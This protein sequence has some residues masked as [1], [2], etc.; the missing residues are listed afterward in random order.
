MDWK[1]LLLLL[2][3]MVR[4]VVH[5]GRLMMT[6][7]YLL[8]IM[9]RVV[10]RVEGRLL[11]LDVVSILLHLLRHLVVIDGRLLLLLRRHRLLLRL[12]QPRK[13][14]HRPMRFIVHWMGHAIHAQ[15]HYFSNTTTTTTNSL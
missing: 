6:L 2:M 1:S 14:W 11:C 4:V 5:R 10:V 8:S 12:R 13:M 15:T 3:C 7:N 9:T